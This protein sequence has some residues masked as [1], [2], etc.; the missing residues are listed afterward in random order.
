VRAT[1]NVG[2]SLVQVDCDCGHDPELEDLVGRLYARLAD[3]A[4]EAVH[5]S[6]H[7]SER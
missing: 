5:T 3:M 1:V 2:G 7:Q 6:L 4:L